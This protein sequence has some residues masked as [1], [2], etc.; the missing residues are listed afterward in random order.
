MQT[1]SPPIYSFFAMKFDAFDHPEVYGQLLA[2]TVVITFGASIP[3][4][5]LA[6][7]NYNEEMKSKNGIDKVEASSNN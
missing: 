4:Y 7:K 2:A 1:L 5:Y 3:F 6:G